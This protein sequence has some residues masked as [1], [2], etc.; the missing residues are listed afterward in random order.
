MG[1]LKIMR[2]VI[3]TN[4]IVSA[5]LFGGIPGEL[6]PLWKEKVIRPL[7]SREI[8]EEHLRVFAYP[9]FEL[10]ENEI[11]FLVYSEMLPWFQTVEVKQSEEIVRADPSDDKFIA[12]AVAGCAGAIVSGDRHLLDLGFF[13]SVQI[14]T[15]SQLLQKVSQ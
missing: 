11:N 2:V 1:T 12:C 9:K 4:V 13:R 6:I 10:T 7:I 15:P 5:L 8:L 3:D 14:M